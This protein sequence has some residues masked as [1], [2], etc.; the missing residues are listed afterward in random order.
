MVYDIITF[1]DDSDREEFAKELT[2]KIVKLETS[3]YSKLYVQMSIYYKNAL[4]RFKYDIQL[5][6]NILIGVI[7]GTA[8]LIEALPPPNHLNVKSIIN[9]Q[10]YDEK[11][12]KITE[13][14]KKS[15]SIIYIM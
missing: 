15:K 14:Y 10:K 8:V 12:R 5:G 7:T 4:F 3:L 2:N 9:Y 1:D 6:D 11:I 13:F